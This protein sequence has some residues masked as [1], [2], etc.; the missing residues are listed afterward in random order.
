MP[1]VL[2]YAPWTQSKGGSVL[3][4]FA[5]VM[6]LAP[7]ILQLA[8]IPHPTLTKSQFRGRDVEPIRGKS[9]VEYFENGIRDPD[10]VDA[11]HTSDDPAVGVCCPSFT[12]S[13]FHL[14]DSMVIQWELFGRAA[15]RK[16]KWKI[17]FMPTWSH[18][19]NNWELFDL[20]ADPGETNNLAEKEP[21]K[22]AELIG[23]W[24]TYVKET[25]V[26][27][28]P[29]LKPG[30][31][32]VDMTTVIGGDPLDDTRAWMPPTRAQSKRRV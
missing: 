30:P 14:I 9:W 3:K 16:G 10:S 12:P 32:N 23:H 19:T 29:P 31:V 13:I 26:V 22:L 7:T 1:F 8:N 25:G 4:T 21:E 5:T 11:I 15:L 20:D 28:G 24:E 17:L 27:W 6:D 18:G 2:N